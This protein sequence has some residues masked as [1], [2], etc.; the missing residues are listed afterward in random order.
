[1]LQCRLD[2]E[3]QDWIQNDQQG[4]EHCAR[5][6]SSLLPGQ[7]HRVTDLWLV[8]LPSFW[9]DVPVRHR[10][11]TRAT[12]VLLTRRASSTLT[13]LRSS[14]S[15]PTL[16]STTLGSGTAPP[17][18][19]SLERH[20]ITDNDVCTEWFF[21]FCTDSVTK[22]IR[23]KAAHTTDNVVYLRIITLFCTDQ[24]LASP[25]VGYLITSP[26][27]IFAITFS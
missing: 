13:T 11:V 9:Q 3:A 24:A 1:M 5:W 26:L 25:A 6:T 27:I 7:L 10:S 17:S 2:L 23:C 4:V 14:P 15:R 12:T 16:S 8:Q 21:L 18:P 20:R 19:S 22:T